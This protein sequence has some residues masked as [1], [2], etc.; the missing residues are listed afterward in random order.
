MGF[1]LSILCFNLL[2]FANFLLFPGKWHLGLN[3]KSSDDHCHHPSIHGFNYFFGIPLTNLRDCQPGHGTVFQIHKYLPYRTLSIILVTA[4]LLHYSG[5]ITIRRALILSLLSLLVIVTGLIAGFIM[6]IPYFNCVLM[7]D[8]RVVEQPFISEN[9][10]Q[11]MTHEATDFIERYMSAFLIHMDQN[12]LSVLLMILFND[13]HFTCR[14]H[15][16]VFYM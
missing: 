3:C 1:S 10:T 16:V 14:K 7:R 8:H 9:L 11:R 15:V 2:S 5:I 4:V 13:Q 12:T 6:I